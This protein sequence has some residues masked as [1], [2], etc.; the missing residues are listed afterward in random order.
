MEGCKMKV[1][2]LS[3]ILKRYPEDMDIMVLVDE[4]GCYYPLENK[5]I[6][7]KT[8]WLGHTSM[9]IKHLKRCEYPGS[10]K[11]REKDRFYAMCDIKEKRKMLVVE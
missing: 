8:L 5:R 11:W 2:E 6:K 4:F 9:D 3:N 7:K 10:P 1:K